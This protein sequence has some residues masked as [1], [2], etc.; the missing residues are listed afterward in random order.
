MQL[1]DHIPHV[2]KK[3]SKTFFSGI[4]FNSSEVKKD[5]IFLQ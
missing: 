5:N 3:Y 2:N 4:A 1:K